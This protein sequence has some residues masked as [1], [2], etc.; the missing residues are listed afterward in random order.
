MHSSASFDCK[1]TPK[2]VFWQCHRL[3]LSPV[4]LTDHES[5][6]GAKSLQAGGSD[7]VIVG[8]E[9][10]TSDGE[11]IGLFLDTPVRSGLTPEAA[12]QEIK[13]QSGLIYLEHPFDQTRR[14]LS[15]PTIEAISDA[16]DIV[17][18]FNG[19]SH[20]QANRRA[21][22]LC[23]TL[24]AA[25]GAGSDAHTLDEIGSVYVEMEAFEGPGDFLVKL[26]RAKIVKH[27]NKLRLMTEA[28]LRHRMR[29]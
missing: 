28:W 21:E 26:R 9:I 17:E 16:I 10:L 11:L 22:E 3:G 15:E 29:G 1:S 18:V 5:I 2:S 12:V 7:G 25:A 8:Q 20:E 19:R 4:F 14:H 6:A 23:A 13:E 24:G 27:P